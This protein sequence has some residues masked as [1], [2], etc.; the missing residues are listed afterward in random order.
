M[1]GSKAFVP[2]SIWLGVPTKLEINLC[3]CCCASP[4][5][6]FSATLSASTMRPDPSMTG[7]KGGKLAV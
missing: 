6:A 7:R 4:L 2:M 1:H 5:F 3:R